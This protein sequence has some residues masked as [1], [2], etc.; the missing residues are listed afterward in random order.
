MS[1]L[2]WETLCHIVYLDYLVAEKQKMCHF[3]HSLMSNI[4]RQLLKTLKLTV[5][6]M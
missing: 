4:I 1:D 2:L 3:G 6:T 5:M